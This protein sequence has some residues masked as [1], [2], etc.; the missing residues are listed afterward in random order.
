[1]EYMMEYFIPESSDSTHHKYI[2][3]EVEKPLDTLDDAE[4]TKEGILEMI[5]KFDPGKGP[6]E[7]GLNSEIFLKIF[8]AFQPSSQGYITSA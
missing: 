2:R 1:M 5:E 7:D 3:H 6:V 8:N 4:F